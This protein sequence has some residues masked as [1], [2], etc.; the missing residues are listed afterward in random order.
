MCILLFRNHSFLN[1]ELVAMT[2]HY[3]DHFVKAL[4][5]RDYVHA[6]PEGAVGRFDDARQRRATFLP[7]LRLQ[8]FWYLG[9][10]TFVLIATG[11]PFLHVCIPRAYLLLEEVWCVHE[12]TCATFVCVCVCVCVY[13]CMCV[14]HVC[15]YVCMYVY[16]YI[17]I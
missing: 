12:L 3:F 2:R 15:M 9:L 6:F 14:M 16:M 7:V 4:F 1:H 17:C 5:S 8:T 13:V 10:R 11:I